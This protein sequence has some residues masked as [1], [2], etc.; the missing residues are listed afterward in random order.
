MV[1]TSSGKLL[2]AGRSFTA[3]SN[4]FRDTFESY[5]SIG[6]VSVDSLT[7]SPNGIAPSQPTVLEHPFHDVG[8]GQ[9][10]FING[11]LS[12]QV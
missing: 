7:S 11:S 4:E 2:V 9:V 5:L 3:A 8:I 12:M 6:Q 10:Y 1:V